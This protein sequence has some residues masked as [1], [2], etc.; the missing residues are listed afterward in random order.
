MEAM[1]DSHLA[2]ELRV[3]RFLVNAAGAKRVEVMRW[4]RLSGGAIQE[5]HGIDV[6]VHGGKH[7]GEHRWVVRSDAPSGVSVS[8]TRAQEFAVLGVAREARVKVPRVLWSCDDGAGPPFFVMERVPGVAA[9]H[10]LVKD[11]ALVPDRAALAREL[12]QN[13]ARLHLVRPPIAGLE[14]LGA[15][16]G[17]PALERVAAYRA[18]L[19]AL[20]AAGA[21]PVLEWG[22]RWCESNAPRPSRPALLH[23]DY[24]TGNYLVNEGRLAAMLDWE[25]AGWGD[26]LEDIGWFLARCWRFGRTDR[27]AGG[28]G[29]AHDFLAGYQSISGR[30]VSYEE[31]RYWQ[32]LAHVRWAII[33]LEQAERRR[34][35]AESS[36]ELALTAH[37]VPEL[38]WEILALTGMR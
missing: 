34:S 30:T 25:F 26:P 11:D 19:A 29:P 32:A 8:R 37:I 2:P 18:C 7:E 38:E 9:G 24:R 14:F 33:A 5:N 15:P 20:R 13:L 21:F 1:N 35:G 10:R 12:G 22:V 28:V 27:E 6:R 17:N 31:T 23:R 16:P 3:A 36:L 4:E